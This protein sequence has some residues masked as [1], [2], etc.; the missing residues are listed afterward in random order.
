MERRLFGGLG[1]V[2]GRGP[3]SNLLWPKLTVNG[4]S[5]KMGSPFIT[6]TPHPSQASAFAAGAYG[7]GD[8]HCNVRNCLRKITRQTGGAGG[9]LGLLPLNA[10]TTGH[11]SVNNRPMLGVRGWES[12]VDAPTENSL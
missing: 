12:A 2:E 1:V 10:P 7:S 9:T 3:G 11:A 4:A 8:N 6:L 5:M